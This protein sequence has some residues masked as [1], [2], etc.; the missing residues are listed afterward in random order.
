MTGADHYQHSGSKGKSLWTSPYFSMKP[1]HIP[2]FMSI[3]TMGNEESLM[4]GSDQSVL[5][6]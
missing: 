2:S 5:I 6:L 3:G 4:H 1:V